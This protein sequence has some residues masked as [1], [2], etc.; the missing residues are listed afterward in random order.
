MLVAIFISLYLSL[1]SLLNKKLLILTLLSIIA[2]A[3]FSQNDFAIQDTSRRHASEGFYL[4]YSVAGLGANIGS[5]L[6]VIEIKNGALLYTYE[7]NSYFDKK[8]SRIDTVCL[9]RVRETSIDSILRLVQNIKDTTIMRTNACIM[10][11]VVRFMSVANGADTT[12]FQ[13]HNTF[14]HTALKIVDILN[15]YLPE[16]KRL[17]ANE[18][19]IKDAEK[20]WSELDKILA[21][22]KRKKKHEKGKSGN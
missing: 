5:F 10:S 12:K 8:D 4:S 14:D 9:V 19:M 18:K 13:L 11:G 3:S 22:E 6:P 20:C 15:T 21:E 17:V 7:Q 2:L 16:E 1:L